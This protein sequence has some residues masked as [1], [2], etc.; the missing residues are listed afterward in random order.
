MGFSGLPKFDPTRAP[1]PKTEAL[2]LEGYGADP[3]S[4]AIRTFAYLVA[5]GESLARAYSRLF[6]SA[7]PSTASSQGSVL[8]AH[9]KVREMIVA[10]GL[11]APEHV[12]A[13]VPAAIETLAAGLDSPSASA[14]QRAADSILDRGGVPRA[15]QTHVDVRQEIALSGRAL[16]EVAAS[17][18]PP[19]LPRA[20]RRREMSPAFDLEDQADSETEL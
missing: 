17:V 1:S 16:L 13:L 18:A 6:P 20:A 10:A 7:S 5:Q 11:P 15:S 4:P 12:R 3:T 14:R 8:A 9:P 2:A 19:P